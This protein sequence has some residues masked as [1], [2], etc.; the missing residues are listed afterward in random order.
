M[1]Y[2]HFFKEKTKKFPFCVLNWFLFFD[3]CSSFFWLIPFQFR[4]YKNIVSHTYTL[5]IVLKS[6]FFFLNNKPI[7]SRFLL[8]R[9]LIDLGGSKVKLGFP[10]PFCHLKSKKKKI[11]HISLCALAVHSCRREGWW[12]EG[13]P[14][15]NPQTSFSGQR[16]HCFSLSRRSITYFLKDQVEGNGCYTFRK[17]KH[18]LKEFRMYI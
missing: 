6:W 5:F 15:S 11:L 10:N 4:T 18:K 1:T 3:K 9:E 16:T 2:Y 12:E 13:G 17:H 14:T 7:L 8:R